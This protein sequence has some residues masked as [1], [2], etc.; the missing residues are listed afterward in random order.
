MAS[1]TALHKLDVPHHSAI[2]FATNAPFNAHHCELLKLVDWPSLQTRRLRHWL[3]LF[4]TLLGKNP[5]YLSSLLVLSR[6]TYRTRSSELIK[7]I[8]PLT[9]TTFGR[10]SF[11]FAAAFDWNKIQD[12]LKLTAFISQSAFKQKL[13]YVLVDPPCSCWFHC[14]SFALHPSHTV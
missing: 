10:N 8:N 12:T 4:K 9:R 5:S 13:N 6:S 2:R 14:F 11:H 3:Q 7:L 1:K